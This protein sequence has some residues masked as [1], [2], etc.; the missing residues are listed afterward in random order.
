VAE[1]VVE[2]LEVVDIAHHQ[3]QRLLR[4]G[5]PLDPRLEF[6]VEGLPVG[7]TRQLI[8]QVFLLDRFQAALQLRD[9][10]RGG[11]QLLLQRLGSRF[12]QFRRGHDLVDHIFKGVRICLGA[13]KLNR[14]LRKSSSEGGV[15]LACRRQHI[16]HAIEFGRHFCAEFRH[17]VFAL[18][19][20]EMVAVKFGHLE[21][22]RAVLCQQA[23]NGARKFGICA[24]AIGVSDL[25]IC[26]KRQKAQFGEPRHCVAREDFGLFFAGSHC[27]S[28]G[29]MHPISGA[30]MGG[31]EER[32]RK[33][34]S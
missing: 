12:H 25:E 30:I 4:L 1:G 11:K 10:A 34:R 14:G 15:I 18:A 29:S 5:N 7:D 13:S 2:F 31:R 26:G 16:Q 28:S 9:F 19:W 17:G 24:F 32:F 22:I 6:R 33:A 27:Q 3:R 8:G 20:A 21:S 23:I